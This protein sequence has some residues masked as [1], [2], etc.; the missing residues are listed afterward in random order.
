MAGRSNNKTLGYTRDSAN[1][2]LTPDSV[3]IYNKFMSR[4]VRCTLPVEQIKRIIE[5]AAQG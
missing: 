4:R 3:G 5:S 1:P 2:E